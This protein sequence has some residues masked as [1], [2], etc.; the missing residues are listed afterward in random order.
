MNF[1]KQRRRV[2]LL[3]ITPLIDVVFILTLVGHVWSRTVESNICASAETASQLVC[4]HR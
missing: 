2:A 4:W 1:R 3:N